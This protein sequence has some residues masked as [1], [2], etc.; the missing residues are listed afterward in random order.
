MTFPKLPYS[1]CDLVST[2]LKYP[3]EIRKAEKRGRGCASLASAVSPENSVVVLQGNGSRGLKHCGCR[4]RVIWAPIL[5]FMNR[6]GASVVLELEDG[7]VA[8]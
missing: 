2:K 8:S 3:C 5:P 1:T 4:V 6:G 7:A